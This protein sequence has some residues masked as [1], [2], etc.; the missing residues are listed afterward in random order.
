MIHFQVEMQDLT[1]IESALGMTKDKSKMVLRTAI[2]NAAKQ[3]E[4]RMVTEAKTKYRYKNATKADIRK[5]NDTKKAKVS[6]MA[7]TIT[8]TGPTNELLDF[9]VKPSTYYPGGKGAPKMVYAKTLKSG[10]FKPVV[11]RPGAVGDQYKGFVVQYE[12]GHYALAQRVPGSH[13]KKKPWKEALK[14]LLSLSAPKMEEKVYDDSIS[15]D[16]ND[17][18]MKN[19]QEQILRYT[20][21]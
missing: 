9:R 12:S 18:L 20:A 4:N 8:A 7:A 15:D 19:I 1:E 2:N 13:M 3:T 21:K 17:I 16:M 5:A 11:L 10:S 14:S 6:N